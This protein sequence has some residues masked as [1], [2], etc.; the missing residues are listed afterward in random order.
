MCLLDGV[1]PYGI[2]P[3]NHD[4]PTTLFN[5]FFP[6]TRFAGEPWYGGHF[7]D[8][9]D[10]SFQLFSVGAIDFLVIHLG[11]CP[12]AQGIAGANSV[13][14]AHSD[15]VAIITTH[16]YLGLSGERSVSECSD[17]QYIWDELVVPNPN[18]H[19]VLTRA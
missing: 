13:L 2:A 9:N 10:N 11:F 6:F 16:G 12:T 7:A 14:K 18:V 15:R 3:G 8:S 19:F 4:L 5:W 1:V 17:T